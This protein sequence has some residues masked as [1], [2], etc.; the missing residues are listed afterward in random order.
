MHVFLVGKNNVNGIKLGLGDLESK[1]TFKNY[2]F[3]C[4]IVASSS[5]SINNWLFAQF[6]YRTS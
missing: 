5:A 3:K 4:L 6:Q 1:K 2:F